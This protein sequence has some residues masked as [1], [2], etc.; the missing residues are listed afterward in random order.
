[1]RARLFGRWVGRAAVFAVLGLGVVVVGGVASATAYVSNVETDS[2]GSSMSGV[3]TEG[4]MVAL[5]YD[6]T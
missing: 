2:P 1:M 5:S 4:V 6:W 3:A